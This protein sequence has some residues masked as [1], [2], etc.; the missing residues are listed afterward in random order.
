[1]DINRYKEL[2]EKELV[3]LMKVGKEIAY[4][5]KTFDSVTG[6]PTLP[7]VQYLNSDSLKAEK[8]QLQDRI[9]AIDMVL[10][11]IEALEK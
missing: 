3:K 4:E 5:L 2:K 11:D 6:E 1:M 7:Q 9:N 8:A 10:A